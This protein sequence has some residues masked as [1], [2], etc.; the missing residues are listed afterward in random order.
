MIKNKENKTWEGLTAKPIVIIAGIILTTVAATYGVVDKLIV[1]RLKY[2]IEKLKEEKSDLKYL[3]NE[4]NSTI[5][6]QDDKIEKLNNLIE[7]YKKNPKTQPQKN[8]I[9]PKV[10]KSNNV[11][12][13]EKLITEGRQI[14]K[15]KAGDDKT[16]DL[17]TEWRNKSI[18][19]IASIDKEFKTSFS[20]KFGNLTEIN[21]S[22]YQEI[23]SKTADG[24][25]I[26]STVKGRIY[27]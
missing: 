24:I 20:E 15:M 16:Y 4:Q 23:P 25:V 11:I 8:N 17:Y 9:Q 7:E 21:L 18:S 22:G 27:Q 13:I 19:L 3:L 12:M 2:D 6:K 26:L 5:E 14:E 1:D 10:P